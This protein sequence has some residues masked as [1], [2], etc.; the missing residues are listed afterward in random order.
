MAEGEATRIVVWGPSSAGKTMFIAQLY[1][2]KELY[3]AE[4]SIRF[5]DTSKVFIDGMRDALKSRVVF[6]PATVASQIEVV[7]Y[8]LTHLPTGREI[9][10]LMEDRPGA[11]WERLDEEGRRRLAVADGLILLFD[12]HRELNQL[13]NEVARTLEQIQGARKQVGVGEV[14]R[15]DPRPYAICLTKADEMI[16]RPGDLALARERPD[17]F[18]RQR[19]MDR[20]YD[21]VLR[22]VEYFCCSYRLY[23]VSS[24]GVRMRWGVVEPVVFYDERMNLRPGWPTG[25]LNLMEPFGYLLQK[26]AEGR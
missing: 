2:L 22:Q 4:W 7:E 16:R 24:V 10:L 17:E 8:H 25:P 15:L 14:P 21:A 12:P 13:L 26:I 19:L 6:P 23:P 9:H 11:Q 18:V 20:G 1:L 5:L 3:M